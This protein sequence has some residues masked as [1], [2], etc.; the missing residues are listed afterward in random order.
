MF[1]PLAIGFPLS[2]PSQSFPLP[3]P[4]FLFYIISSGFLALAD[5]FWVFDAIQEIVCLVIMNS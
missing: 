1:P 3:P 5:K 4:P 2:L